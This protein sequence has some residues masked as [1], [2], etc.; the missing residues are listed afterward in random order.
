M[1]NSR[2]KAAQNSEL[3]HASSIL[4]QLFDGVVITEDDLER[5]IE[6]R[7]T[8]SSGTGKA[9]AAIA[10]PL[11]AELIESELPDEEAVDTELPAALVPAPWEEQAAPLRISLNQLRQWYV[12][13]RDLGRSDRL[14]RITQLGSQFKQRFGDADPDMPQTFEAW[15]PQDIS[16]WIADRAAFE[17]QKTTVGRRS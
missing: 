4:A 2:I 11:E 3:S 14:L 6:A 17:H 10:R 8:P 15:S 13:A 1:D 16:L 5:P 9:S 7:T 12:I